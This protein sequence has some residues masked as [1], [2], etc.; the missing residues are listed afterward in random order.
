MRSHCEGVAL[1]KPPQV[2][3]PDVQGLRGVCIVSVVFYHVQLP[4]FSG[5]F[6]GV[7][8]FFVISGFLIVGLLLDE[9][10]RTGH[11]DLV[12]F[13]SRRARRLLPNA[14]VALIATLVVGGVLMPP[15]ALDILGRDTAAAAAYVANYRFAAKAVDYFRLD[16]QLSPV[17]HYWSL[18]IEEQFYIVWPVVLLAAC[19]R[20]RLAKIAP[21]ALLGSIW[22]LSFAYCMLAVA[23]NQPLTFFHT[24]TRCWQLASGGLA[25]LYIRRFSPLPSPVGW[26]GFAAIVAAVCSLDDQIAY[27]GLVALVPTIG[28]AGVLLTSCAR[29]GSVAMVLGRF[30]LMWIGARSYSWYLWHWPVLIYAGIFWPGQPFAALLSVPVSLAVAH[31]VFKHLEDPVRRETVWLLSPRRSLVASAAAIAAILACSAAL[32]RISAIRGGPTAAMAEA[33]NRASSDRGQNYADECHLGFEAAPQRDCAYGD[34]GAARRVVLFGDSHAAQWFPAI[35]A[36]ASLA[37]WKFHAWTKSGCPSVD[38]TV[39]SIPRRRAYWECDEWRREVLAKLVG[40]HRPDLVLISNHTDYDGRTQ[41][42]K[43]GKLLKH[44]AAR[45]EWRKGLR[46]TLEALAQAGIPT[47]MIRDTPKAF[48]SFAACLANGGG[49]ACD[50]PRQ[51]AVEAEPIDVATAREFATRGLTV[52]DLTDRLC[53]PRVCPATQAGTFVYSDYHHITATFALSL[54]TDFTSLLPKPSK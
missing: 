29:R 20:A 19:G 13:W 27:P 22:V 51:Q 46:L 40:P 32:P 48:K 47:V 39:W 8:A 23:D 37:G 6:V 12:R 4:G 36:A 33:L 24:E 44:E 2:H 53:S 28:V 15:H 1:T 30:S 17:L 49:Q 9:V 54:A 41:D 26:V 18:S 21:F 38:I 35:N 3:R 14:T 16:D 31:Y 34:V 42:R 50:R 25:A 5:G 52:L 43:T 45:R 10:G 11:I 7:D